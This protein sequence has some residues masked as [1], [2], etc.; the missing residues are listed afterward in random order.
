M[1]RLQLTTLM[2]LAVAGSTLIETQAEA[3]TIRYR[4]SGDWTA[5]AP[6]DSGPGWQNQSAVPGLDDLG[7]LNWGNNTVTVTTVE[8]IG[9]LQIAVD[10]PGNLVI[11]NGGSLSTKSGSGQNGR[12]IV[13]NND[14][15]QELGTLLVQAGGE[16]N[17]DDILF[18]G[19]GTNGQTTIEGTANVG[20]H[21]WA[22]W[23]TG[24]TG[25]IVVNDGGILNVTGMIGLN[26]QDNGAVG[27]LNINDGGVVNLDQIH[28]SG[29]SIQG[30]SLLTIAGTGMLTKTGNFTTVIQ[31]NYVNTGKIVGEGGTE[32]QVAYDSNNDI[33]TVTLVPEPSSL[34]FIGLGGLALMRRRRSS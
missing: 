31:D 2:A 3:D 12:L 30:T 13:G 14:A 28:A 18:T 1:K 21:L 9:Q 32:L 8:Q 23:N 25:T 20:S 24:V 22:G 4:Q 27:L 11:A 34:A 17:T 26:W 16:V 5:T 29:N 33:T 6:L 10:E 19:L 15:E 7:R